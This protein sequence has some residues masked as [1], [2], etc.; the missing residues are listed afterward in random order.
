MRLDPCESLCGDADLIIHLYEMLPGDIVEIL[1]PGRRADPAQLDRRRTDHEL[2]LALLEVEGWTV[3]GAR[4]EMD[5]PIAVRVES[6]D[7]QH[8]LFTRRPAILESVVE[9]AE[10]ALEAVGIVRLERDESPQT[11]LN[12]VGSERV[13]FKEPSRVGLLQDFVLS[14]NRHKRPVTRLEV[15]MIRGR[16]AASR[17]VVQH[18]VTRAQFPRELHQGAKRIANEL[19]CMVQ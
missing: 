8:R 14:V 4:E 3:F 5:A 6:K 1:F 16:S 19:W 17:P 13:G 11:L 10:R 15:Q 2:V 9:G 7:I 18:R 12:A